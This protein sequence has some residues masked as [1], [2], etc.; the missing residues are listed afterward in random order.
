MISGMLLIDKP[1]GLS[2]FDVVRWVRRAVGER[3]IG[4][5]GTLDPFA[6][7]LL[8]LCLGEATKL[9]PYLMPGAKNYRATLKLGVATDTQDLTGQVVSQREARPEAA[10]VYQ[11]AAGF[12]GEIEQVPPMHSALHYQGQRLYKLAR[13]GETVAVPP[14]WVTIYHLEVEEV[15]QDRVTM[16]VKCSAGTYIRTLAADLGEALGCGAHL[17][18]L[19]RLEVGPFKVAAAI[20]LAALEEAGPEE[21]LAQIIPLSA[22]LPGMPQVRVGADDAAKLRQGQSV[23]WEAEGLEADEPVQVMAAGELLAVAKIRRQAE[24]LVLTPVRVFLSS[25][26][27]AV[28]GQQKLK[29]QAKNAE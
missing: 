13:R 22:C 15:D 10:Q 21:R 12:V 27:S 14:R 1:E 24:R 26:L 8:P 5:L 28:S 17:T 3:K 25:Q 11:A 20:T 19:R 18:A 9:V 7:G 2:S 29:A 4:H 6:T 23:A 16:T